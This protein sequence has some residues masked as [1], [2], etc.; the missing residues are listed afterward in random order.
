[1]A[2]HTLSRGHPEPGRSSVKNEL[3]L[4]LVTSDVK[5]AEVLCVSVVLQLHLEAHIVKH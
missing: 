3:E 4:S 1:M 5:F 2:H